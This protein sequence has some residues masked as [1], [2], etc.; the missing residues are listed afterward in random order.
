MNER[1]R[2]Y[3]AELQRKMKREEET[4]NEFEIEES[5]SKF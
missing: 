1:L 3:E 2:K 4:L 5:S